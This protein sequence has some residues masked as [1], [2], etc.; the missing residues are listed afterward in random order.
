MDD[1]I[2]IEEMLYTVSLNS[3]SSS[4]G[5]ENVLFEQ[6][7]VQPTRNMR[8]QDKDDSPDEVAE[9]ARVIGEILQLQNTLEDLSQRVDSVKEENIKLK[10]ENEVLGK[11]IDN[12]MSSSSVFQ[13]SSTKSKGRTK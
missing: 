6:Q 8:N 1:K 13:Q 7:D 5:E 12:L 9:K 2:N 4:E 11:Y 3:G 10:S